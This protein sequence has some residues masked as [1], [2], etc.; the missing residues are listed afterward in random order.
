VGTAEVKFRIVESDFTVCDETGGE[1][2]LGFTLF[3]GLEIID[4]ADG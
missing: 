4:S 3:S 2:E 1:V